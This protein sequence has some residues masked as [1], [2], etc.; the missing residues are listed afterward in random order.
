M[1]QEFFV[2]VKKNEKTIKIIGAFSILF[3]LIYI[4]FRSSFIIISFKDKNLF[5]KLANTNSERS[6]GLM[7]VKKLGIND[8]MVFEFEKEERQTFWMKDTLIPLD[9][10]WIDQSGKVVNVTS[11]A[12]PCSKDPC[13]KYYSSKPVKYVIELNGGWA[14][15]NE[16]NVGTQVK[17]RHF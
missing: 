7:N 2:S 10:V 16:L 8:G 17:I 4:W 5:L 3:I 14:K 1:L 12:L 6:R 15:K 13:R 11:N 9:L